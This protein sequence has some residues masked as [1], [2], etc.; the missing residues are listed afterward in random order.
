MS[1]GIGFQ[2][3]ND[4]KS[5]PIQNQLFQQLILFAVKNVYPTSTLISYRLFLASE[6][7]SNFTWNIKS[8]LL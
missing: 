6:V 5:I 3:A 1:W 7:F 8:H 2:V 4:G